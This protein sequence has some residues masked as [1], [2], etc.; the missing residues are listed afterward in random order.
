MSKQNGIKRDVLDQKPQT[1]GK[2]LASLGGKDMALVAKT[3]KSGRP[4]FGGNGTATL[5][6]GQGTYKFSVS[7][8]ATAINSDKSPMPEGAEEAI[9]SS[10]QMTLKE[11]GL[12]KVI[13]SPREFQSG[14]VGFYHGD[15]LSVK[16]GD[17]LVKFQVGCSVVAWHSDGWAADRDEAPAQQ[18]K[19][20]APA[21]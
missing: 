16:L 21:G 9:L 15:K 6:C 18:D 1:L 20:E 19:D 11:L 2:L 14:K 13:A 5:V 17:S 4:G 7:I 8:N 3:F 12:D 10:G